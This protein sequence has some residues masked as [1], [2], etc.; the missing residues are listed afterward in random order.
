MTIAQSGNSVVDTWAAGGGGGPHLVTANF[1]S[2]LSDAL[3]LLALSATST[4]TT[5][6]YCSAITDNRGL[7]WRNVAS[8]FWSNWL[9]G[10]G[11]VS[12]ID[13][14]NS[15]QLWYAVDA[16]SPSS[17]HD[18]TLHFNAGVSDAGVEL[19]AAID[20]LATSIARFSGVYTADPFDHNPASQGFVRVNTTSSTKPQIDN[21]ASTTSI[22][23]PVWVQGATG[24]LNR[25]SSTCDIFNNGVGP[26]AAS[27]D[28]RAH[29]DAGGGYTNE[30]SC[31]LQAWPGF[32][33]PLVNGTMRNFNQVDIS[34]AFGVILTADSQSARHRARTRVIT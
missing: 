20:G 25:P 29:H 33:G 28:V 1:G 15:I 17:G 9:S 5:P 7:T 23:C 4:G 11:L 12:D 34:Q 3:L 2:T 18:I 14:S 10:T 21:L 13:I 27:V 8:A 32:S 19:T 24:S 6:A 26:T 22:I 31:A 30:I 16:A